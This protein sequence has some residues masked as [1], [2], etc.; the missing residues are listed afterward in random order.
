MPQT[1]VPERHGSLGNA[2]LQG[3]DEGLRG[4]P[5][6]DLLFGGALKKKLNGLPQVAFGLLDGIALAGDINFRTQ[7][8][9]TII[10]PN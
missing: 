10:I 5:L 3:R 1:S 9:E 8:H 4:Q 2:Y 6:A 7:S